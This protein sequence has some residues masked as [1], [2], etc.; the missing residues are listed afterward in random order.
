MLLP[1]AKKSIFWLLPIQL[2]VKLSRFPL[3]PTSQT[4]SLLRSIKTTP[5]YCSISMG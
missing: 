4:K 3:K 5:T 2:I 1:I